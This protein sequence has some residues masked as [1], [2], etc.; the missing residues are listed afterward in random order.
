L[1]DHVIKGTS[2]DIFQSA[3]QTPQVM[4]PNLIGIRKESFRINAIHRPDWT[5]FPH[6]T[7]DSDVTIRLSYVFGPNLGTFT[8][9]G[10]QRHQFIGYRY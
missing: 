9:I 3:S 1:G 5:H 4:S 6:T 10:G 2:A 8:I 7:L